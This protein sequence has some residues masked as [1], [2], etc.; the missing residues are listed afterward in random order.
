MIG[1]NTTHPNAETAHPTVN[2]VYSTT[3]NL[4]VIVAPEVMNCLKIDVIVVQ[5]DIRKSNKITSLNV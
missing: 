5:K 2:H 4:T 1:L 3:K